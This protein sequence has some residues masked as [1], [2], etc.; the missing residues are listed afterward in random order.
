MINFRN[1]KSWRLNS[2]DLELNVWPIVRSCVL[3]F[4]STHELDLSTPLFYL[5]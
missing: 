5:I 4:H 3:K 1:H 2:K